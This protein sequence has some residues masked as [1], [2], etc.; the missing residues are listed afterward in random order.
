MS[1]KICKRLGVDNHDL[2]ISI[3]KRVL[4]VPIFYWNDKVI[5]DA[6]LGHD[7]WTRFKVVGRRLYGEVL[8]AMMHKISTPFLLTMLIFNL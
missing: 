5:V 8:F 6:S 2:V 7:G 4:V 3:D 1:C